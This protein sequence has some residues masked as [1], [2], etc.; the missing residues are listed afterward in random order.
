MSNGLSF[1]VEAEPGELSHVMPGFLK[2]K[3]TKPA[4]NFSFQFLGQLLQTLCS[5]VTSE[6]RREAPGAG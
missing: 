2:T 6:C 1:D 4:A 3:P 5:R